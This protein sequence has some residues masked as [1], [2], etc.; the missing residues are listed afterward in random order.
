MAS[1]TL[2]TSAQPSLFCVRYS[3]TASTQEV[4]TACGPCCELVARWC[5]LVETVVPSAQTPP[6]FDMVA[7]QS[8]PMKT[9]WFVLMDRSIG[10]DRS[11]CA[12]VRTKMS[13]TAVDCAQGAKT[14]VDFPGG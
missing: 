1:P 6:T 4:T 2:L 10:E 14:T 3:V 7:P 8:V 9:C 11:G 5:S 13:G 12:S